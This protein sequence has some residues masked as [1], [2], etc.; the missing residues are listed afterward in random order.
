MA[1]NNKVRVDF[2]L[3]SSTFVNKD[4]INGM[5]MTGVT[6]DKCREEFRAFEHNIFVR[7][8]CYKPAT[9]ILV[10]IASSIF[11]CFTIIVPLVALFS[12]ISILLFRKWF[13]A[14]L[15]NKVYDRGIKLQRGLA[16]LDA[17]VQ[18]EFSMSDTIIVKSF[19]SIPEIEMFIEIGYNHD[20]SYKIKPNYQITASY[21]NAPSLPVVT[22]NTSQNRISIHIQEPS[23][24]RDDEIHPE[25]DRNLVRIQSE[26]LR[27]QEEPKP[28]PRT[29]TL[30]P[31]LMRLSGPGSISF[32]NRSV[33]SVS[34]PIPSSPKP[35]K[36]LAQIIDLNQGAIL[37]NFSGTHKELGQVQKG[38]QEVFKPNVE[39]NLLS[40]Q[41]ASN[42]LKFTGNS[43]TKT[44]N[45]HDSDMKSMGE[46]LISAQSNGFVKPHGFQQEVMLDMKDGSFGYNRS[47]VDLGEASNGDSDFEGLQMRVS[48]HSWHRI[49]N[50]N[51]LSKKI[52]LPQTSYHYKKQGDEPLAIPEELEEDVVNPHIMQPSDKSIDQGPRVSF[53]RQ[54]QDSWHGGLRD[55]DNNHGQEMAIRQ[56]ENKSD[57]ISQF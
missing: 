48:Q 56:N 38:N 4:I 46:G 16:K 26:N 25:T 15:R 18:A 49:N 41:H 23:L 45:W 33:N 52:L 24:N 27:D 31:N 37:P 57:R 3:S 7:A 30:R 22:E 1:S 28:K 42:D 2:G 10:L 51:H 35:L 13:Y 8:I 50:S 39:S 12:I 36:T 43:G 47:R 40:F 5:G 32:G 21:L 55:D 20:E 44:T 29:E 19:A 54:L 17:F 6:R 53:S 11:L 14:K 9:L 34:S